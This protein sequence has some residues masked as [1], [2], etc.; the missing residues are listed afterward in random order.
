MVGFHVE[1]KSVHKDDLKF[2]GTTC[3][4]PAKP[5]PQLVDPVS[6]TTLYFT[7]EVEW[8]VSKIS[9]ASRWDTY[10][11][12][13]DAQIHWFSIINSIVVIF[14]LSGKKSWLWFYKTN[15]SILT[16][17]GIL[18]MIMVRTLRRDIARYNAD[19]GID[20]AIEETGWKLVHGDVFRPPKTSRLFAAVIGS[21]IQ[22]LLMALITLCKF[23][24]RH[25]MTAFSKQILFFSQFLP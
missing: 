12:M 11:A 25:L 24:S 6:G 13:S 16:F 18:T 7:Y 10:L 3:S 17:T 15:Q 21:G 8:E 19:E 2:D 9:W 5:R 20:E 23:C 1:A 4:F 14:F 22:I